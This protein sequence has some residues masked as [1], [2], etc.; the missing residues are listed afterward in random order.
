MGPADGDRQAGSEVRGQRWIVVT[1][2]VP[3][4]K[5]ELAYSEAFKSAVNYDANKDYPEYSDY[6]VERVEVASPGEAAD[7]DWK[8]AKSCSPSPKTS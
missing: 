6:Q 3:V 5:Q 7:P 4:E 8:D 1:G 2:L